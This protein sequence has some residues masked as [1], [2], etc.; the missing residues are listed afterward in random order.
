MLI[1]LVPAKTNS[2]KVAKTLLELKKT[3]QKS[4]KKVSSA[5]IPNDATAAALNCLPPFNRLQ[6]NS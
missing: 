1:K 6:A 3:S 2:K 5:N 4:H